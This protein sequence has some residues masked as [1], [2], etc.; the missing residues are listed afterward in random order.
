M[1][2]KNSGYDCT[3]TEW[4]S[5]NLVFT[6]KNFGIKKTCDQLDTALD[7]MSFSKI[8]YNTFCILN[9]SLESF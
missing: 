7:N 6:E 8:I 2:Y 1:Q 5:L 4:P 9:G 3:S